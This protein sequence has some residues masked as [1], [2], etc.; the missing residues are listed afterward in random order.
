MTGRGLTML[1]SQWGLPRRLVC[2]AGTVRS[3]P[4]QVQYSQQSSA[5]MVARAVLV[6]RASPGAAQAVRLSVE[7]PAVDLQG[8]LSAL[9]PGLH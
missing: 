2:A 5:S 6:F 1:G 4:S 9:S 7:A 3:G 8:Q